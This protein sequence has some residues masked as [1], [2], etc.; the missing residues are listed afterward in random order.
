MYIG[1]SVRVSLRMSTNRDASLSA[2]LYSV[3]CLG[4]VTVRR[5]HV[6]MRVIYL[7]SICINNLGVCACCVVCLLCATHRVV[8]HLLLTC[9]CSLAYEQAC[10]ALSFVKSWGVCSLR[11]RSGW[12]LMGSLVFYTSMMVCFLVFFL[13]SA[14]SRAGNNCAIVRYLP[15]SMAF[16]HV[17]AFLCVPLSRLNR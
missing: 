10:Y 17:Q 15:L 4:S 16:S 6:E 11:L 1:L 9:C 14:S 7:L 5:Y 12:L 13:S 3:G 8:S 2:P